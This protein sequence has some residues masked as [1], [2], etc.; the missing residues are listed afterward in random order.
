VSCNDDLNEASAHIHRGSIGRAVQLLIR[1]V[2][3]L[4]REVGELKE[5]TRHHH[6]SEPERDVHD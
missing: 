4:A 2:A 3:I 1:V 5:Q 6:Q